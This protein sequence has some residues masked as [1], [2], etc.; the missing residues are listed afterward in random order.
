MKQKIM[1]V[2]CASSALNYIDDIRNAGYDPVILEPF[3]QENRR[4]EAR[5]IFDTEYARLKGELPAIYVAK[6]SYEDTL[7]MVREINP[8]VILPGTDYALELATNLA[9]DLGLPGNPPEHLPYLR[10]KDMMQ[11]AVKAAGLRY[12]R[13][14]VVSTVEEAVT[15]Y[16]EEL[17]GRPAIV[18]PLRG[19]GSAGVIA[20]LDVEELVRAVS[21]DIELARKKNAPNIAVLIQEMIIGTEYFANTVTLNG[22][23]VVTNVM[24]YEKR[25]IATE[26]PVYVRGTAVDSSNPIYSAIT[27]YVVKVVDAVGLKIGPTHTEVMVDEDGP[28]LIE[29]NARLAG[30]DQ[31]AEWQDKVMGLHESDISLRAYLGKDILHNSFDGYA[32]VPS[33]DGKYSYYNRLRPGCVQCAVTVNDIEAEGFI[34]RDLILGLSST[35]SYLGFDTPRSYPA[36]KDFFTLIGMVYMVNDSEKQLEEDFHK[37]LD[38]EMN[39]IEEL[40]RLKQV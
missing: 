27:E 32:A 15:Y 34:G 20:C 39:H 26:R 6:E 31:P 40:F 22:H 38:I 35:Y 37:L 19:A 4:D 23:T 3:V 24:C 7:A 11:E 2:L 30:A 29:V 12:I 14:K 9:F 17:K 10:E 13:G 33:K 36:T 28:V 8:C 18:K 25:L 5:K 21:E 16:R 1:V